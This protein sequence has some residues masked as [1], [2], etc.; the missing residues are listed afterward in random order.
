MSTS[1]VLFSFELEE[2]ERGEEL[3]FDSELFDSLPTGDGPCEG[4][5]L[6]S[7]GVE[8]FS[9]PGGVEGGFV[10]LESKFGGVDPRDPTRPR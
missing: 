2:T 3:P 5:V 6:T 7:F 8:R 9:D 10:L 4:E 1:T